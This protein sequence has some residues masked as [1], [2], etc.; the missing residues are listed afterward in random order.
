[1]YEGGRRT[2]RP[3]YKNYKW[4]V[5]MFDKETQEIKQGKYFTLKDLNKKL[6]LNLTTDHIWRM[7]TG[8]RV[9][10]T[11]KLK[12]NSFLT[13]FAH[14]KVKKIKEAVPR[15]IQETIKSKKNDLVIK[16]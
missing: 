2:G 16:N 5:I 8:N 7:T 10:V 15:D 1:M 3:N 4:E 9:D 14:I 12:D 6:E 13:K 11:K